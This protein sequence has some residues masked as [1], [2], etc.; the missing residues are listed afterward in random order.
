MS[1]TAWQRAGLAI[2]AASSLMLGAWAQFAPWSF[3]RSFPGFGASWVIVD[4]PYNEHL[5]RDVGGL[6]L[7]LA[8]VAIVAMIWTRRATVAAASAGALVYGV[9]HLAYHLHH[10]GEL[11]PADAI[12]E[13]LG[14]VI[15]VLVPLAL[16]WSALAGP[17]PGTEGVAHL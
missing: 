13:V 7:A 6:N 3:Y 12:S 4:G 5:V 11:T 15:V 14:L 10:V 9:P 16:L 17:R 2:L 1:A 8:V